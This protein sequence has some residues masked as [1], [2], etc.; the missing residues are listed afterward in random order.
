MKT[1]NGAKHGA[2]RLG[3]QGKITLGIAAVAALMVL[4]YSVLNYLAVR[5]QALGRLDSRLASAAQSYA[6]VVDLAE[7]DQL[8]AQGEQADPERIHAIVKRLTEY[9]RSL[10][11]VFLYS[12]QQDAKEARYIYSSLEDK[13]YQ[14]ANS[15]TPLF[16]QAYDEETPRATIARVAA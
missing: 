10:D 6:Y 5:D 14:D 9:A 15:Y 7:Q 8:M 2:A 3:V 13:E 4:A 1:T 16:L 11:I 12:L